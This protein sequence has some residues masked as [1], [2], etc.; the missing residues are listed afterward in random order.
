[1]NGGLDLTALAFLA[2]TP[3]LVDYQTLAKPLPQVLE[4]LS[5]LVGKKLV[6]DPAMAEDRI[7]VAV[8]AVDPRE[9]VRRL[10]ATVAGRVEE[11][12]SLIRIAFDREYEARQNKAFEDKIGQLHEQWKKELERKVNFRGQELDISGLAR[13]VTP[14]RLANLKPGTPVTFSSPSTYGTLPLPS[15]T[16]SVRVGA[17]IESV[18]MVLSRG[19]REAE[20]LVVIRTTEANDYPVYDKR[21]ALARHAA[22]AYKEIPLATELS[23]GINF[24]TTWSY[25]VLG[26]GPIPM[27]GLEFFLNHV[28][29]DEPLDALVSPV[30]FSA[31]RAFDRD[32]VA[33]VADDSIVPKFGTL[34]SLDSFLNSHSVVSD[35][36]WI[37]IAPGSIRSA[38][39]DRI[40]RVRMRGLR[41]SMRSTGELGADCIQYLREPRSL[42]RFGLVLE[43]AATNLAAFVVAASLPIDSKTR[44]YAELQSDRKLW[45]SLTQGREVPATELSRS[46]RQA[47]EGL[48]SQQKQ[49]NLTTARNWTSGSQHFT[50]AM[51]QFTTIQSLGL[52]KGLPPYASIRLVKTSTPGVIAV[53]R[54]RGY[55]LACS[56]QEVA[57]AVAL[58]EAGQ[59]DEGMHAIYRADEFIPI[60]VR[61]YSLGLRLD[62][63]R[64]IGSGIAQMSLVETTGDIRPISR[65]GLTGDHK[66]EYD[67]AYAEFK[68][69]VGGG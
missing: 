53:S 23:A 32:I 46:A 60:N 52:D 9:L 66:R 12:D 19:P 6:C 62:E 31:A 41:S 65:S 55:F 37:L 38:R 50:E 69:M 8:T 28:W 24:I 30:I 42:P 10:A 2:L 15:N 7:V 43:A 54:A 68:R 27:R 33:N 59:G 20:V 34:I 21:F 67:R 11:D 45:D 14:Q 22:I 35:D 40:N 47:V 5:P 56:V 58:S 57:R 1:M 17:D 63:T 64:S 29:R 13:F 3:V 36:N 44:P 48:L 51:N 4:E 25:G 26:R 16:L 18:R 61:S 49:V 39:E